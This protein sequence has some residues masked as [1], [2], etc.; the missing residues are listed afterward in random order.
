M[1]PIFAITLTLLGGL[2]QHFLASQTY[3][4]EGSWECFV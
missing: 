1:F 3:L 4:P 2:V